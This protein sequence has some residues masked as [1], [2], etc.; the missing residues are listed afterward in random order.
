VLAAGQDAWTHV[1]SSRQPTDLAKVVAAQRAYHQGCTIAD[2][3]RESLELMRLPVDLLTESVLDELRAH[4][5]PALAPICA[6][7]GGLIGQE[8][9]KV[10]SGKDTPIDNFLCLDCVSAPPNG[11]ARVVR[12]AQQP[13][14]RQGPCAVETASPVSL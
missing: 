8:V 3:A 11:G 9:I 14:A 10:I 6:I 7:L 4:A 13:H 12:L 5:A 2:A 1:A